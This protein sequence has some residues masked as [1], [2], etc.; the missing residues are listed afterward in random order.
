MSGGSGSIFIGADGGARVSGRAASAD[1]RGR[2]RIAGLP[3]GE[4]LLSVGIASAMSG[5]PKFI[6]ITAGQ[7][8]I[9]APGS[10]FYPGVSTVSQASKIAVADGH[11]SAGIDLVVRPLPAASINVTATAARPVSEIQLHQDP[12]RRPDADDGRRDEADRIQRHQRHARCQ[13][14]PI[15]A[16]RVG[17]GGVQRRQRHS[18]LGVCGCRY[19]SVDSCRRHYGSG[20]RSE[21]LRA[22]PLRRQGIQSAESRRPACADVGA[23]GDQPPDA[24]RQF[25]VRQWPPASSRSKASCP[26]GR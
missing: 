26:A 25:D 10:V 18:S 23:A 11:E 3:P 2:Y 17:G 24:R 4:Y 22:D 5:A 16:A 21:H 7:D 15:P 14:R 12:A 20:A 8:R 6:S 13:N 1:A 19:R 9:L